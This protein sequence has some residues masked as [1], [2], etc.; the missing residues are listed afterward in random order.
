[1]AAEREVKLVG[2]SV[3]PFVIR[4][5]IALALKG[6]EYENFEETFGSKSE[7]LLKSNPVYKKVPVLIHN[8]KPICESL[9]IVQ[10]IDDVWSGAGPSIVP[11]DPF[12]AAMARF[13]SHYV[14]DK[15][16]PSYLEVVKGETR[17]A[18]IDAAREAI[19]RLQ[20]LEEAFEKQIKGKHFF[21]GETIGFLDIALGSYLVWIKAAEKITGLEFFD[22]FPNLSAWAECFWADDV[23]KAVMPEVDAVVGF[24]NKLQ[25]KFNSPPPPTTN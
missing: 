10:Y 19:A 5:K 25:A 2:F 15:W 3:S 16:F 17:E 14:D 9:I 1:M 20:P 8:G 21:G 6:V 23:V 13:W 24:A 4:A 11:S 22:K 18:K 7:L 12:D